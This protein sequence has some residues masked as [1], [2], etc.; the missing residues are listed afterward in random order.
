MKY[1]F[2]KQSGSKVSLSILCVLVQIV[3]ADGEPFVTLVEFV[4]E[5]FSSELH[6]NI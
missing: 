4:Q 5:V 2:K 6:L 1:Y 3:P